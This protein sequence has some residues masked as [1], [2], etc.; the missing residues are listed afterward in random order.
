MRRE[1]KA[2]KPGSAIGWR[3]FRDPRGW[4]RRD[5]EERS[6][7]RA[8]ED[9]AKGQVGAQRGLGRAM[10]GRWQSGDDV[11]VGVGIE[12]GVVAHLGVEPVIRITLG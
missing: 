9:T 5:G 4:G 3:V 2:F 1:D 12:L 6:T 7:V 8:A 11:D 10:G